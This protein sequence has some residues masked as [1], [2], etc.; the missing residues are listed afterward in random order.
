MPRIFI[1]RALQEVLLRN[2][3]IEDEMVRTRIVCAEILKHTQYK[4]VRNSPTTVAARRKFL[5]VFTCSNT[6]VVASNPIRYMD[7][8]VCLF[9]DCV[10][11]VSSSLAV[12]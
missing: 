1:I 7:V 10:L 6:R 8:S 2:L 3:I 12:G 5:T 4:L 9:S 11:C